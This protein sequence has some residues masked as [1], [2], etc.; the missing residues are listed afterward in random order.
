MG[1]K[2]HAA[3]LLACVIILNSCTTGT[4]GER[5]QRLSESEI[6]GKEMSQLVKVVKSEREWRESLTPEQYRVTREAGT[7]GAFT[8]Q[9]HKFNGVGSYECVACG[10]KLFDSAHKFSSGTGWPS[11]W[12]TAQEGHVAEIDDSGWGMRRVEVLCARCDSHLGH[13]FSDGPQPTGMRYCVNS[14]AL[15]FVAALK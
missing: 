12:R 8:G 10:L 5:E 14:A 11:F 7:E 15:K 4:A 2:I 9:Y 6:G 3:A 1:Q 13:V